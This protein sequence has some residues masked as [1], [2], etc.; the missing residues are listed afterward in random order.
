MKTNPNE[1]ISVITKHEEFAEILNT[2]GLTKREY[3]AAMALQGL[4]ANGY[5][6]FSIK[7]SIFAIEQADELIKALN[8]E[9]DGNKNN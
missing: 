4:L 3:F 7:A 5:R 1:P 2:N 8:G 6:S 9:Y